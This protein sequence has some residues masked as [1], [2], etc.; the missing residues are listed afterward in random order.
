MPPLKQ[1]MKA[2]DEYMP[3]VGGQEGEM[4]GTD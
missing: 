4:G 2:I 1:M 3:T